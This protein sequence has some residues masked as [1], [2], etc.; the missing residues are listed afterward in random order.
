MQH[1]LDLCVF[2]YRQ[3]EHLMA[4][5]GFTSTTAPW[6]SRTPPPGL[7]LTDHVKTMFDWDGTWRE[8]E[9]IHCGRRAKSDRAPGTMTLDQEHYNTELEAP[10]LKRHDGDM[11]ISADPAL[12]MD[13]RSGIGSLAWV[14]GRTRPDVAADVSLLRDSCDKLTVKNLAEVNRCVGTFCARL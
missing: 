2:L 9:I 13:Y 12:V 14:A 1:S 4:S 10:S 3:N 8:D 6:A 5:W 11:K 7:Q